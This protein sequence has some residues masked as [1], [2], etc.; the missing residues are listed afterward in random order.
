[1]NRFSRRRWKERSRAKRSSRVAGGTK[2]DNL[3]KEVTHIIR[4]EILGIITVNLAFVLK[5]RHVLKA[6]K[7]K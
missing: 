5:Y 7:K 4:I 1:M 2:T 6:F 3:Y